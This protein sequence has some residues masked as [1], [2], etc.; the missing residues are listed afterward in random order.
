MEMQGGNAPINS[1]SR[2]K[3]ILNKFFVRYAQKK[4]RSTMTISLATLQG[5]ACMNNTLC[6]G[7]FLALMFFKSLAWEFSAE[8]LAIIFVELAMALYYSLKTTF[9]V[10][11]GLA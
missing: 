10:R 8:T 1:D 4:T 2:I 11:D 5:A 7:V 3:K 9:N 6:L